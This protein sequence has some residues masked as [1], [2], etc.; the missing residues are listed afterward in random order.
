[1]KTISMVFPCFLVLSLIGY[2]RY[3]VSKRPH[4]IAQIAIIRDQ[5][6]SITDDCSRV[7]GLSERS[8]ERP[9]IDDGSTLSL[10]ILGNDTTANEPR[11]L[12]KFNAPVI[13]RVIE[14]QRAA[15]RQKEELLNSIKSR[16]SQVEQIKSSPIFQA[17][18]RGTEYLRTLGGVSDTRYL[19]VQTDGEETVEPQIKKALNEEFGAKL[20]LPSPILN[21][22]I[23]ITFCGMAETVGIATNSNSRSGRMSKART[24]KRADRIREVWS[25]L[26]TNP[27]L[28]KFEPY[29][30]SESNTGSNRLASALK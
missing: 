28:V 18:K 27:E 30:V 25:H 21:K 5:S 12:G 2:W 7:V 6:D 16:C 20:S 22:D 4:P 14:G 11:L 10:F 19:L 15:A 13:R 9:D 1:M 29:C 26:F 3:D 17:A 24:S 23:L 8:L